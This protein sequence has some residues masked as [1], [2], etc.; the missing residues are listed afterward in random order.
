M[1]HRDVKAANVLLSR[2]FGVLVSDLGVS[3]EVTRQR[4]CRNTLVGSPLWLAPEVV[5]GVPYSTPSDIW[6]FGILLCEV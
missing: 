3:A 4:A 6:S 1:I 5:K 2:E